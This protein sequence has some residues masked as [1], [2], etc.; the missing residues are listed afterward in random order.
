MSLW[1]YV[2]KPGQDWCNEKFLGRTDPYH[3]DTAPYYRNKAN[4][5]TAPSLLS[6]LTR[7]RIVRVEREEQSQAVCKT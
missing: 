3:K 4:R 2:G 6:T 1:H 7:N 5:T